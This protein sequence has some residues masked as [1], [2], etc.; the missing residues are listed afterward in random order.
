NLRRDDEPV[1]H[2]RQRDQGRA[3]AVARQANRQHMGLDGDL[4]ARDSCRRVAGLAAARLAGP[5]S[6]L[7]GLLWPADRDGAEIIVG[8]RVRLS[9]IQPASFSVTPFPER[10]PWLA[11][12]KPQVG[13]RQFRIIF[14]AKC[15]PATGTFG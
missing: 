3:V 13:P 4:P 9:L 12:N 6:D 11:V 10:N 1:L 14:S 8:R 2:C 7:S 15:S 5:A